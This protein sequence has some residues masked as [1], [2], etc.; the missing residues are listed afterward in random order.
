MI[1]PIPADRFY[2]VSFYQG[3]RYPEELRCPPNEIEDYLT[4][5]DAYILGVGESLKEA[6]A[7][8]K[9]N[10]VPPNWYSGRGPLP[11]P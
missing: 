4:R 1:K 3:R 10:F 7:N 6:R 2:V 9:K 5:H 11:M 8:A